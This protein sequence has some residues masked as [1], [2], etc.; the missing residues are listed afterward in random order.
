MSFNFGMPKPVPTENVIHIDY[1]VCR[2]LNPPK[3]ENG[4]CEMYWN[5]DFK[6][7]VPANVVLA[8]QED[9]FPCYAEML[10][11]LGETK[12]VFVRQKEDLTAPGYFRIYDEDGNPISF[13]IAREIN[14]R[15]SASARDQMIQRTRRPWSEMLDEARV[16]VL[17]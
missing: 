9:W 17:G 8:M 7:R 15:A 11:C 12:A 4:K 10:R 2:R 14:L 3:G 6:F 1:D 5:W 16:S 13:P